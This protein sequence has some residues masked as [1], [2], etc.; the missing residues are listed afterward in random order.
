M[1]A[2]KIATDRRQK[3][4]A[5]G[6]TGRT[7]RCLWHIGEAHCGSG[8]RDRLRQNAAARSTVLNLVS[9]FEAPTSFEA[10]GTRA[11]QLLRRS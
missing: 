3:H 9:L 8:K 7:Y 11:D 4:A 5:F 2:F 6:Q 10:A 1:R